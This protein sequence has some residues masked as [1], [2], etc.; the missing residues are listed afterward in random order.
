[1]LSSA[2][3][4]STVISLLTD[5]SDESIPGIAKQDE[6]MDKSSRYS[7]QVRL[8]EISISSSTPSSL[9][10]RRSCAHRTLEFLLSLNLGPHI[11]TLF[12]TSES[13]LLNTLAR[14]RLVLPGTLKILGT[15]L[16]R[17]W[18]KWHTICLNECDESALMAL[19]SIGVV[20]R[21][22]DVTD[23]MDHQIKYPL[24]ASDTE[25]TRDISF[26]KSSNM[27]DLFLN[28]LPVDHLRKLIHAGSSQAHSRPALV[29]KVKGSYNGKQRTIFG[30]L[31]DMNLL[32]QKVHH[33]DNMSVRL[34]L[35][36]S[37]RRLFLS[38]SFILD[39]DSGDE[40]AWDTAL[41]STVLKT[42]ANK[43]ITPL[44]P[45]RM[46]ERASL[47]LE[48]PGPVRIYATRTQVETTRLLEALEGKID[49][50]KICPKI[51]CN[52]VRSFLAQIDLFWESGPEW[53][54]RRQLPRRCS[55]L[56]WKCVAELERLKYYDVAYDNLK[57]LIDNNKSVLGKKRRGKV[58]IRFM[59]ECGH[60][61]IDPRD[62]K[63]CLLEM[64][65]FE[66][67]VA[68]IE[69]RLSGLS[70]RKYEWPCGSVPERTIEIFGAASRDFNWVEKAAL[71]HYYLDGQHGAYEQG[72]H[73][74]GRAM[75]DVFNV[76][77]QACLQPG[78]GMGPLVQSPIQ[79]WTLD[80]G[81]LQLDPHRWSQ[82]LSV[83]ETISV[84]DFD[85]LSSHY[86]AASLSLGKNSE[87]PVESILSCMRG[88][89]LAGIMTLIAS[90]PFYWGGGQPDLLVWDTRGQKRVVFSE[91]KGPGDH[92]SPRQRWWLSK[93]IAFGVD[94]EVCYVIDERAKRDTPV[95]KKH[96]KTDIPSCLEPKRDPLDCVELD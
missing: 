53:W 25:L 82:V 72:L 40:M 31:N 34:F 68:E 85:A 78:I 80:A 41:P 92:L 52:N 22:S 33:M 71:D 37:C 63:K 30:G 76:L 14:L 81:Y 7:L 62:F 15:L 73:C 24:V 36:E 54:W 10:P 51:I 65:L 70:L 44:T 55:N 47:R 38:L 45:G 21:P 77:F 94:A 74:E 48:D 49:K 1:M 60:L 4:S 91:V 50:R 42:T 89:M 18:P 83:V 17:Q 2:C 9:S 11:P 6:R 56:I 96:K 84:L 59:I 46:T 12:D 32:V 20:L 93:L 95:K 79:R 8:S 3:S 26:F 66:A 43:G 27:T 35:S 39:L 90:D 19:I 69:R 28:S 58:A 5:S 75:M 88:R 13:D 87:Y 61:N 57:F 64:D 23:W 67:D 29:S 16:A 86:V